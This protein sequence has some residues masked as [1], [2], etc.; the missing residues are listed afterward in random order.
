MI[1][2]PN[3]MPWL[4]GSSLRMAKRL[5]E[6]PVMIPYK[7]LQSLLEAVRELPVLRK[8]NAWQK[9]QILALRMLYSEC[10]EKINELN[11]LI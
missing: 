6:Y 5:P 8:E 10:L 7:E 3:L 9:E 2:S 1:P 4:I 11:E